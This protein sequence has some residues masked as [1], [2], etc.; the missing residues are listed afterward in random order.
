MSMMIQNI[1]QLQICSLLFPKVLM[2]VI[3]QCPEAGSLLIQPIEAPAAD[4][5]DE[6]GG[7]EQ[8]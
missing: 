8:G 7:S 3:C 2:F 4:L 6:E 1:K 5:G